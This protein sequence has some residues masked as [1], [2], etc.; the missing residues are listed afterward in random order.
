MFQGIRK[1]VFWIKLT[2][3]E[4]WSFHALYAPL[5]PYWIWLCIRSRTSFFINTANPL[6]KNGGFLMESKKEIYDLIPLEYYP[7]TL[8]VEPGTDF[9]QLNHEIKHLGLEYP[10]IAKPDIGMRG[11]AVKKIMC[12]NDLKEYASKNKM[13]YLIQSF[14]PYEKEVGIFYVRLPYESK[15]KITGIVSKEFLKLIGDG[16]STVLEL[17]QKNNRSILQIPHF[18][19]FEPNTLEIVIA[20]NEELILSPYGN[21]ARGAKFIDISN[22]ISP[23]LTDSINQICLQIPEFYFGRLDI[24][25]RDWELLCQGKELSIIELNGAGSE[26]TH[27]YDP[28]HSVFFAWA[29]IIRHWKLLQQISIYNHVNQKIPYMGWKNGIQMLKD[30]HQYIQQL[31]TSQ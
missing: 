29:E 6:I 16:S 20:K 11:I 21:H 7:R 17:M 9:D 5:Y 1:S 3:W 4:Y 22:L 15:G 31:E 28:K 24:K 12:L 13:A 27:I 23:D 14:V 8:L 2:H 26:P 30:N 18:K 19:K 25:Y 10:L